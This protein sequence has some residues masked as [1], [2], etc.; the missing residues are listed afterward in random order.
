MSEASGHHPKSGLLQKRRKCFSMAHHATWARSDMPSQASDALL[1]FTHPVF[2]FPFQ[3]LHFLFL[4]SFC[5][6]TPQNSP[7][8]CKKTPKILLHLS[9]FFTFVLLLKSQWLMSL[10]SIF[11]YVFSPQLPIIRVNFLTMLQKMLS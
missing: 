10:N 9:F 4:L 5:A 11:S 1:P 2:S 3:Y 7:Q 6:I 8:I